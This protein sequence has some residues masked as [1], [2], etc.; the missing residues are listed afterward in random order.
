MRP[1]HYTN[2]EKGVN[3][4]EIKGDN[5]IYQLDTT[6]KELKNINNLS[7]EEVKLKLQIIFHLIGD[8]H[9][10]LHIGYGSDKGG[11]AMQINFNGKGSNLH[12]F[13]DSGIIGLKGITLD[14]CLK[15]NK[16]SESE[17]SQIQN[18]NVINWAN[19]SRTYLDRIYDLNGNKVS[20]EYVDSNSPI[21][22]NQILKAGLRLASVLEYYF[23]D[24]QYK[25][26]TTNVIKVEAVTIDIDEV[27]DY[28]GKL[29]KICSRVYGGI[30]L[31]SSVTKLTLLN[32]GGAYPNSPLTIAIW[33]ENRRNFKNAP[34]TFY[35]GKYICV[36]GKVI[37]YKGK[38]EI[39]LSN[40]SEIEVKQ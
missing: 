33:N 6:I 28:V 25:P 10:P 9:Q 8:L 12:S 36:I 35:I 18:I 19:E 27:G 1:Y 31:D 37:M 4:V 29:V 11:N 32:V 24:A 34:E 5:I 14:D 21:I 13:W 26:S 38:S 40:E 23:K 3:V 20:Q 39:I 7:N 16:Y 30:Y 17:L 22:K 2:F 15:M